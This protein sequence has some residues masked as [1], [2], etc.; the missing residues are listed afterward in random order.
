MLAGS[1]VAGS[2][3]IPHSSFLGLVSARVTVRFGAARKAWEE[4]PELRRVPEHGVQARLAAW[5]S[6]SQTR[7]RWPRWFWMPEAPGGKTGI[8]A[9]CPLPAGRVRRQKRPVPWGRGGDGAPRP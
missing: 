8:P 6:R 2:V 4:A 9:V 5:W 1:H 3:L 7:S